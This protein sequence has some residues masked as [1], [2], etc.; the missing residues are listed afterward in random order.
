MLNLTT[1]IYKRI[2][3]GEIERSILAKEEMSGPPVPMPGAPGGPPGGPP[4]QIAGAPPNVGGPPN[5]TPGQLGPG[6]Q[7]GPPGGPGGPGGMGPKAFIGGLK[8]FQLDINYRWSD[9]VY[10]ERF[11]TEVPSKGA[12]GDVTAKQTIRAGD[13][14]PDAPGLECL[15]VKEGLKPVTRLFDVFKPTCHTAIIFANSSEAAQTLLDALTPFP[16]DTL[17]TVVVFP[18]LST[19]QIPSTPEAE[20]IFK[21]TD[22]HAY[23][24]YGSSDMSSASAILIRPDSWIGAFATS[25]AGVKEYVSRVFNVQ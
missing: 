8:L 11:T 2:F 22:G 20:Y 15:H 19:A 1:D 12:Y 16:K 6:G 7:G 18:A 25:A 21:D 24:G 10:D 4:G 23:K 14:A 13:R 5:G 17:Q 9:I 3:S